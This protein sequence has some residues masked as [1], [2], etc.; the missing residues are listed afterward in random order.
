MITVI[1]PAYNRPLELQQA[2]FSLS[3]QSKLDFN[4]LV[5]DD[6]STEDLSSICEAF[7][8]LNLTYIKSNK[9]RGCGGN[10]RFALEY[11]LKSAPTE[12]V[13]WLDSDDLLFPNAVERLEDVIK[14]N[15]A[16]IILTDIQQE[17]PNAPPTVIKAENSHTWMHGKIYRTQFLMDNHVTFPANLKTNEDLAFNLSLYAYKPTVYLL[18]EAV[19]YFRHNAQSVTKNPD[20]IKRCFSIDY[21]DAI[22][23]A[24]SCFKQEKTPLTMMLVSNIIHL[25]NFWQRGIIFKT[26][27]EQHKQKTRKMI[28]DFEVMKQLVTAYIHPEFKF[29]WDQWAKDGQNLVFFGQSFGAW[30]M[31]FF[32]PEEIKEIINKAGLREE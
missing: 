5:S 6:A 18:N 32:K 9:N 21:I 27:T 12:Y 29:A 4:V 23:E 7:E 31:T 19:Y 10:R 11:F 28:R 15:N 16:D 17:I 24:Y 26:L 13:M 8:N 20:T 25:Y 30:L 1:I 14:H 3:A 22:Y 2:L